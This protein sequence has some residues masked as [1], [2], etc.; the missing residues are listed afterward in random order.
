MQHFLG[1]QLFCVLPKKILLVPQKCEIILVLY[2]QNV[3][4]STSLLIFFIGFVHVFMASFL[5]CFPYIYYSSN[6]C[7]IL[8]LALKGDSKKEKSNNYRIIG[9]MIIVESKEVIPEI[10]QRRFS[11]IT[12]KAIFEENKFIAPWLCCI[13]GA[14]KI[15]SPSL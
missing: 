9:R 15:F 13:L 6:Y 11:A 4:L 8:F 7:L 14:P 3:N 2:H 12:K 1:C 10:Q 5:Y